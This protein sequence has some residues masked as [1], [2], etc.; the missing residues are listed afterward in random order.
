MLE[1][2]VELCLSFLLHPSC[3]FRVVCQR[4]FVLRLLFAFLLRTLVLSFSE[5]ADMPFPLGN[6]RWVV[7]EVKDGAPNVLRNYTTDDLRITIVYRR[8]CFENEERATH[9]KRKIVKKL[10]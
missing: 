5:W 2:R 10:Y 3:R 8:R 4:M 6:D 9:F 7:Q 1:I